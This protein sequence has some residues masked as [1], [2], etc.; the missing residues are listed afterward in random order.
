MPGT[1]RLELVRGE[2]R[3]MAPSGFDHGAIVMTFAKPTAFVAS[4]A[5]GVVVGGEAGFL[6]S[7]PDV[8]RGVDI[9]FVQAAR[10]VKSGR[11][12]KYWDGPPDLAMEIVSPND[13]LEEVE[14]KVDDYLASGTRLVWVV[15]P[16]RRTVT[17]NQPGNNPV[18]LRERETLD[19]GE[20][21]PGFQC[22]VSE[23]FS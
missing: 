23:V 19:G 17:V 16:R 7:Q 22:V 14:E 21:L 2:V 15:N 11:P 9:G 6:L 12:T 3:K 13:T 5:L 18:I 4:N 1:E 10:I 8:V 20:V